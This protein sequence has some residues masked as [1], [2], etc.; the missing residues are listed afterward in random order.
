MSSYAG[1]TRR[2]AKA[3][4]TTNQP[5]GRMASPENQQYHRHKTYQ[6]QGSP[7]KGSQSHNTLARP[8]CT[9]AEAARTSPGTSPT[10]T[11]LPTYHTVAK[12]QGYPYPFAKNP[13]LLIA[14]RYSS[15]IDISNDLVFRH[16]FRV[17]QSATREL[18]WIR[19]NP[20]HHGYRTV[21]VRQHD[22]LTGLYR[23]RIISERTVG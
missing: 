16:F 19:E 7:K 4:R 10:L 21:P 20:Y 8:D 9:W 3:R 1:H 14:S 13:Y 18:L 11:I 17:R 15:N 23:L 22:F 6:D 2:G 12:D 5:I